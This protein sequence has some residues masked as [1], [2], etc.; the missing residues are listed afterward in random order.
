MSAAKYLLDSL[1][2]GCRLNRERHVVNRLQLTVFLGASL[3]L[4]S[5]GYGMTPHSQRIASSA[6]TI[7]SW[8]GRKANPISFTH[9]QH[10]IPVEITFTLIGKQ[11][12]VSHW[13]IDFGKPYKYLHPDRQGKT[14]MGSCIS[15]CSQVKYLR[16]LDVSLTQ[17]QRFQPNARLDNM[18]LGAYTIEELWSEIRSEMR[19]KLS[20]APGKKITM[21][22]TKNDNLNEPP[23]V[24][25]IAPNRVL[26]KS[27]TIEA[28]SRIFSKHGFQVVDV[29]LGS[30]FWFRESLN[31]QAWSEISKLPD[32]GIATPGT[33]EFV[34]VRRVAA[35]KR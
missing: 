12:G 18:T 20:R 31:G 3:W 1:A 19:S 10:G 6:A 29:N 16:L 21:H 5:N 2:N 24:A 25:W 17:F 30:E 11:R 33:I 8:Y 26:Q 28:T 9:S 22:D 27:E 34:I 14:D 4:V 15:V 32:V 23:D 13:A 7:S 35:S